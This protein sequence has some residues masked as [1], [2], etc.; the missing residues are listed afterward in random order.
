MLLSTLFAA[1]VFITAT[2]A[3]IITHTTTLVLYAYYDASADTARTSTPTKSFALSAPPVIAPA[4][5]GEVTQQTV[6]PNTAIAPSI[7]D[8][9]TKQTSDQASDQGT[10]ISITPT[11]DAPPQT[12]DQHSPHYTSI[13]NTTPTDEATSQPTSHSTTPTSLLTHP[14]RTNPPTTKPTDSAETTSAAT[15]IFP[16][17]ATLLLYDLITMAVFVWCWVMGIF[18]WW[19]RDDRAGGRGRGRA[20]GWAGWA[21]DERWEEEGDRWAMEWRVES[22]M[23]RVGML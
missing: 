21:G 17:T 4:P 16:A 14:T 9:A 23:R 2:Q 5:T 20:V 10:S 7:T 8:E 13:T 3:K 15:W 11:D 22:E 18:W 12:T 1:L 6:D 19:R